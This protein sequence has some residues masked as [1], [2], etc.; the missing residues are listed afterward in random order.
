MEQDREIQEVMMNLGKGF[1]GIKTGAMLVVNPLALAGIMAVRQ[2]IMR[3]VKSGKLKPQEIANFDKFME[4]FKGEHSHLNIPLKTTAENGDFKF[5]EIDDI[6]KELKALGIDFYVTPD[7]NKDDN[8]MQV[9]VPKKDQDTFMAWYEKHTLKCL[10]GGE[11][12]PEYLKALVNGQTTIHELH[13]ENRVDD[14]N[15]L[16][17]A[18]TRMKVNYAIMPD[19]NI[20]DGN[21]HIMVASQDLQTYQMILHE[22]NQ[23]LL[24]RGEEILANQSIT[25][26]QYFAT[27][28]V[29]GLD[30]AKNLDAEHERVFAEFKGNQKNYELT[31]ALKQQANTIRSSEH[32]DYQAMIENPNY[33]KIT[34]PHKELVQDS[35]NIKPDIKTQ[36]GNCHQ[37]GFFVSKIP[38]RHKYEE[39]AMIVPV[40]QVFTN[41]DCKTY[42]VFIHRSKLPAIID[43]DGNRVTE[44]TSTKELKN[45]IYTPYLQNLKSQKEHIESVSQAMNTVKAPVVSS[46]FLSK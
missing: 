44:Y 9:F 42:D 3:L 12:S 25:K 6:K 36:Y 37:N 17:E 28:E 15:N 14:L 16:K 32:S 4:K 31:D 35:M 22:Y 24:Q 23:G 33:E 30:Y 18:L 39:H 11:K 21:K 5:Y 40:T 1:R 41:P 43:M 8:L 34:V 7:L 20:G 45:K 13:L 26:E 10:E 19:I 2:I 29:N 38:N 46:P 27:G